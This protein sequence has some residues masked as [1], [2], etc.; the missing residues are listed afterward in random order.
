MG[1][2]KKFVNEIIY[3]NGVSVK[4]LPPL[5]ATSIALVVAYIKTVNLSMTEF[6]ERAIGHASI[7]AVDAPM[8]V[9]AF[10]TCIAIFILSFMLGSFIIDKA[11]K[12]LVSKFSEHSFVLEKTLFFELG[13]LYLIN[14]IVY[15]YGFVKNVNVSKDPLISLNFTI[16]VAC[17]HILISIFKNYK[18]FPVET[19]FQSALALLIP[20]PLTYFMLLVL[21]SGAVTIS[22]ISIK[23]AIIYF[24]FYL[25]L[26]FMLDR[27]INLS[28]AACAF[29]PLSFL[30]LAYIIANEAQYT[31][32]KHGAVISPKVIALGVS[33]LLN[34]IALLVYLLKRKNNSEEFA[35]KKIENIVLPVL[36]VTVGIFATHYQVI[37]PNFD[38]LHN[39]NM[40]LPAQQ[41]LQ[42]GNLPLLDIWEHQNLPILPFLYGILNGLNLL[43]QNIW[44]NMSHMIVNILICYFV[45]RQFMSARWAALLILFTPIISY[46]NSYYMAGLLPLIYLRKMRERRSAFDYG[47]FFALG[48]AAFVYHSSSG[49]IA[50]IAGLVIIAMSCSS[51]KNIIDAIKGVAIVV[52]VPVIV[53]FS[54]VLLRGENIL[55][56]LALISAL[57][58][59]DILICAYSNFIGSNRTPFEILVYLGIFP[60]LGIASAYLAL[61][62]KEKTAVNYSIVF[63]AVATIICSLRSFARHS[64]AE[65][66][67]H[68]YY[69]LLFVLVPLVLIKCKIKAKI[70]SSFVIVVLLITPYV[71]TGYGIATYGVK[72]F[73]FKQFE[74]GDERCDT[75]YNQAY[76]SNLRKVLDTVLT[77]DQTFFETVNGYLLYAL[78]ERECTFLPVST[79]M[80]QYERPQVAYIHTLEKLYEKNK[81]PI[82]ITGKSDW[83][84]CAI[85][86]IPSELS[87]FKLEEWIYAHYEPWIW[88]DGFHLWKAKNSGIKLPEEEDDKTENILANVSFSNYEPYGLMTESN[89][90]ILTLKCGNNDPQIYFLLGKETETNLENSHTAK[91][92]LSYKSSVEGSLQVFYNFSG[93]NETDSS[94]VLISATTEYE[95][96]FVPVPTSKHLLKAVRID[97]P[98][99][100]TF[101]IKSINIIKSILPFYN[102]KNTIK[103]DFSMIMLPYVWGNY[104]KKINKHFPEEQQHIADNLVLEVGNPITLKL[105]SEI[106]KS[107]GNYI[108]FCINTTNPGTMT[109]KYGNDIINSCNFN[110]VT[111]E[112]NYLVRVSSQYN[113]VNEPQAWLEIVSD[114]PVTVKRVSVLKGD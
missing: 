35:I 89:S 14:E 53:Y 86:G 2:I 32:T 42:F 105:D 28:A 110:I 96:V 49:F 108:Y 51:K 66:L 57:G 79:L 19:H 109:L 15:L 61:R 4:T 84:G 41:L 16:V 54:L 82:I 8:R 11:K 80:I 59:Q 55:D 23:S 88:V 56:R 7:H 1:K 67:P 81:V 21:S 90:G 34:G 93:Y 64:L 31:L 76:P 95:T 65:G 60:L 78:M 77:D 39:G 85:D 17:V 102:A 103:Q 9:T 29:I 13:I 91:L 43:E 100:A 40:T 70:I 94:R 48:L 112:Y 36:L 47:V 30:P 6:Y 52:I 63:I 98:D 87:L 83:W 75:F 12:I 37:S 10:W 68:D 113:W 22:V 114:I 46:A 20:I 27:I 71:A 107:S 106:D 62:A 25:F 50:V 97:P 99:G 73:T 72:D 18:N 38:L 5:L 33:L 24:I 26:R 69:P 101:E 104:D 111:G 74:A 3:L 92:M 44:I 58:R 45:L